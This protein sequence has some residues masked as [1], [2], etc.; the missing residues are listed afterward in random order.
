MMQR[1]GFP[2]SN[3]RYSPLGSVYVVLRSHH[4]HHHPQSKRYMWCVWVHAAVGIITSVCCFVYTGNCTK[5]GRRIPRKHGIPMLLWTRIDNIHT[6]R[7]TTV[8]IGKSRC[9][10]SIEHSII[11][12]SPT[13]CGHITIC[14]DWR[15]TGRINP[16]HSIPNTISVVKNF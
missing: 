4:L 14:F 10:Q 12:I 15:T 16:V 2:T 7:M 8:G 1:N 3:M 13:F 6:Q 11:C 9:A 5:I